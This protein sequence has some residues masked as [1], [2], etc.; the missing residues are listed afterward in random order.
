MQTLVNV[1]KQ[2]GK[3][4]RIY[5]SP[6]G[7]RLLVL[8]H[9]G[10]VLGLF[11]PNSEENFYWTNPALA[12]PESARAFYASASWHNSGGDRTWLAPEVDVSSPTFP[13]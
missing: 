4:A 13:T 5:K 11:A 6:D 1:L 12:A 2:A 3:P 8:P 10:R 7:T 9:G